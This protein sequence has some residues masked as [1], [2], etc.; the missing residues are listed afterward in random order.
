MMKKTNKYYAAYGSNLN[1]EQMA[2]RCPT[3][4]VVAAATLK[5]YRLLFRG[6]KRSSVA[7][8]EPFDGGQVPILI[9]EITPGDETALDQYEGFPILYRKETIHV[10]MNG[11]DIDAMI[12]IMNTECRPLGMPSP[13]YYSV[14]RKGYYD[15]GFDASV[16]CRATENSME[17]EEVNA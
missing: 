15:A 12:Y 5:G 1:L 11:R 8:V 17:T 7:T 2:V 3:A 6:G 10:K 9:W 13:Y 4:R 16:L 14:I